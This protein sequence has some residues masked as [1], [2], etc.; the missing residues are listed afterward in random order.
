MAERPC[1]RPPTLRSAFIPRSIASGLG[2]QNGGRTCKG[3]RKEGRV[4]SGVAALVLL[5]VRCKNGTLM[6]TGTKWGNARAGWTVGREMVNQDR[7]S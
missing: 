3:T 4:I 7:V 1:D 2:L 6:A 5:L